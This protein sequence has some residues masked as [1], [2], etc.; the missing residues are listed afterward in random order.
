MAEVTSIEELEDGSAR[1]TIDLTEH[2]VQLLLSNA[3]E[4]ALKNFI[5]GYINE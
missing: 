2:E 3:I 1:V 4:T 5:E